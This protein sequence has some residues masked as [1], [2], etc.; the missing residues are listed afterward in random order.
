MNMVMP[1]LMNLLACAVAVCCV[2]CASVGG[3]WKLA[4]KE[5]PATEDISGAWEGTWLSKKSG[6][7]GKLRC[8]M[9]KKSDSE[10]EAY[11]HASFWKLFAARYRVMLQATQTAENEFRLEGTAEIGG[12]ASGE[13]TY[14]GVA[15]PTRYSATYQAE[16]DHGTFEMQRVQQ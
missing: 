7:K 9:T 12:L 16:K 6:H 13:Y 15:T 1:L 5:P 8:L 11:F 2:G 3:E 10:Y 14:R 4:A